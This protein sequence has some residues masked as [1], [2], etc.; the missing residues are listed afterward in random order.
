MLYIKCKKEFTTE[1]KN[2]VIT[3]FKRYYQRFDIEL[4]FTD[5]I[6]KTKVGKF[7]YLVQNIKL[8]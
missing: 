6:E 5:N 4:H 7:R 8:R 1:D 2:S 3:E